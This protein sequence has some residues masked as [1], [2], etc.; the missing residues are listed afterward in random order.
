LAHRLVGHLRKVRGLTVGEYT[1]GT[2]AAE[3]ETQLGGWLAR[4]GLLIADDS[5]E[6][7]LNLQ[8]ADAVVHVRLP[9]S[10]NRLEQRLGRVDR[11]DRSEHQPARQIIMSS[12]EGEFTVPGAW[13]KLLVD[14]FGIFTESLSTLQAGI[15]RALPGVWRDAVLEGPRG[16]LD[17]SGTVRSALDDERRDVDTVD[18]LDAIYESTAGLRDIAASAAEFETCWKDAQRALTG[19]VGRVPGGLAMTVTEMATETRFGTGD[20]AP[21]VPPRL[22]ARAVTNQTP[23][24]GTFNREVALRR[25]GTR[26]LRI[27]H[28]FVDLMASVTRIDDKGQAT[29]YWR[30]HPGEPQAFFGFDYLV[31]ADI[32]PAVEATDGGAQAK[33]ALR[34]QAD[35][36]LAPFT[37]RIWV[38]S[39]GAVVR[40]QPL[41]D[42]LDLPYNQRSDVNL[43]PE[44]A[45]FLLDHF[46]G[47]LGFAESARKADTVARGEIMASEEL[48]ARCS[49]AATA[50]SRALVIARAQVRA[51]QAAGRLLS[52]TE[53]MLADVAVAELLT[54]AL[55]NPTVSVVSVTCCIAGR[56]PAGLRG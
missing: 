17:A 13:A 47:R 41:L 15:E 30:R 55:H 54:E 52:D 46:G 36:L 49:G 21:L 56:P 5:A 14:G 11:Y 9:S 32:Q 37:T 39:S 8:R 43:K 25:P 35:R 48:T 44:R 53:S 2:G 4:G 38:H 3:C 12:T 28:P 26:V 33:Q 20:H 31:E 34:R 51:R 7:G 40:S 16:L 24:T 27:G 6:D 29:A 23:M 50:A 18:M 42:L 22:L 10:P 45:R 19:Y 1:A